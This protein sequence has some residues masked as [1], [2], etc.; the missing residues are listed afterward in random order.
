MKPKRLWALKR[1][2]KYLSEI[3][4]E[5]MKFQEADPHKSILYNNGDI[6]R[7]VAYQQDA[8][9]EELGEGTS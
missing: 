5:P 3:F 9:V 1:K 2:G 6:A 7:R 4:C 8:T